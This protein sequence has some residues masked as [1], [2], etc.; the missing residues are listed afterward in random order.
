M[1]LQF[2]VRAAHLSQGPFEGLSRAA[3]IGILQSSVP[4]L[5]GISNGPVAIPDVETRHDYFMQC[6][7]HSNL[8]RSPCLF[9]LTLL[10]SVI[11]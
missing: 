3:S 6:K 11:G 9:R 4:I 7:Y 2:P 5:N 10:G 8:S 1:M